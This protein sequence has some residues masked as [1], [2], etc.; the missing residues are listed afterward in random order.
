[1]SWSTKQFEVGSRTYT[2]QFRVGRHTGL[3]LIRCK[4]PDCG[5]DRGIYED[6]ALEILAGTKGWPLCPT[7]GCSIAMPV[8]V[9]KEVITK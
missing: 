1:M 9:K 4:C 6:V 5:F 2:L 7:F 8:V 3:N